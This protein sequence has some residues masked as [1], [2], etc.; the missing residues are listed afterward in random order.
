[1]EIQE[2]KKNW[3]G[4]VVF[5]V[6]LC[7]YKFLSQYKPTINLFPSPLRPAPSSLPPSQFSSKISNIHAITLSSEDRCHGKNEF[8]RYSS[9]HLFGFREF[10]HE[11]R[12]NTDVKPQS[13]CLPLMYK[14]YTDIIRNI[15]LKLH[16]QTS[17]SYITISHL[18]SV[19]VK[20]YSYTVYLL[21]Q[22]CDQRQHAKTFIL[23]SIDVRS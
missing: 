10:T 3:T 17:I 8:E 4:T 1:M 20:S 16:L 22:I 6:Q 12:D 5:S 11:A 23:L 19:L 15:N 7:T 14:H 9:F 21:K 2:L 13:K 18:L